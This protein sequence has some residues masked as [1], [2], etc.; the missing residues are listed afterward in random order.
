MLL[1]KPQKSPPVLESVWHIV[2]ILEDERKNEEMWKNIETPK[3]SE[4]LDS[5][6]EI[7]NWMERQS[8]CDHLHLLHLQNITMYVTEKCQQLL[9]QNKLI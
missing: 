5:I 8:D 1:C 6:S 7:K 4:V 3:I 9:R 2:D